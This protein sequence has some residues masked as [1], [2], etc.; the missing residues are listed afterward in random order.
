[1]KV[2]CEDKRHTNLIIMLYL[3]NKLQEKEYC[4]KRTQ[5]S[6]INE[7]YIIVASCRGIGP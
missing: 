5:L 1:M 4:D 2:T 3:S 7:K 6:S